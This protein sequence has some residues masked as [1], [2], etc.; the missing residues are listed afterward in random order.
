MAAK[1][2]EALT[3]AELQ[4]V[5]QDAAPYLPTYHLGQLVWP[6]G[7]GGASFVLFGLLALWAARRESVTRRG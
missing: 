5:L 1:L 2:L 6:P 4:Q 3:H 7:L